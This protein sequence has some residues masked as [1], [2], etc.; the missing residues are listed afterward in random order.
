MVVVGI[1]HQDH[2]PKE[3]VMN[4][5]ELINRLVARKLQPVTS[6]DKNICFVAKV[7]CVCLA[8]TARTPASAK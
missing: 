2:S 3:F 8:G 1:N 7:F 4:R 6:K 5:Q